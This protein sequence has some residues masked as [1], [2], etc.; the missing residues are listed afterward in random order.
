MTR[1][2]FAKWFGIAVG[3]TAIPVKAKFKKKKHHEDTLLYKGP[4]RI[5]EHVVESVR[6][7][8]IVRTTDRHWAARYQDRDTVYLFRFRI[9]H[10]RGMVGEI[11]KTKEGKFRV[12]CWAAANAC[13]EYKEVGELKGE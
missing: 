7:A 4:M 13:G 5:P 2:E 12:H 11:V 1:R 3:T 9:P 8:E 10:H 6:E